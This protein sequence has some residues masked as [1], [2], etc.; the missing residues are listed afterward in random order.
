M[1]FK[2]YLQEATNSFKKGETV[3]YGDVKVKIIKVRQDASKRFDWIIIKGKNCFVD[4]VES[5]MVSRTKD[6]E[7]EPVKKSINKEPK[8]KKGET[9]YI[10]ST[11]KKVKIVKVDLDVEIGIQVGDIATMYTVKDASG[12]TIKNLQSYNLS[13]NMDGK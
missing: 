13:K 9:V 5:Y 8:F 12:K 10:V 3:Y 4:E 11:G 7:D 1:S 6:G 2:E